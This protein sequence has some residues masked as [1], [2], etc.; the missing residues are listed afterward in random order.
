MNGVYPDWWRRQRRPNRDK[1]ACPG[2][3]LARLL[4][5]GKLGLV[6]VVSTPTSGP[7]CRRITATRWGVGHGRSTLNNGRMET[8]RGPALFASVLLQNSASTMRRRRLTPRPVARRPPRR[9]LPAAGQPPANNRLA[10]RAAATHTYGLLQPQILDASRH[11]SDAGVGRARPSGMRIRTDLL[12]SPSIRGEAAHWPPRSL[13]PS[14][15]PISSS[16]GPQLSN[17]ALVLRRASRAPFPEIA[18]R[19]V[20]KQLSLQFRIAARAS[21]SMR[22]K[23][24]QGQNRLLLVTY[25]GISAPPAVVCVRHCS[26]P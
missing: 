17:V 19:E 20:I 8:R 25:P 2:G 1:T 10:S 14:Q 9:Y 12:K 16:S 15:C 23:E 24:W 3:E 11:G 18:C 21:K 26:P 4:P 13:C 7:S 6:A 5:Y 22:I